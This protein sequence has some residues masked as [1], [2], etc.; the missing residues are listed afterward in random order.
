MDVTSVL[1]VMAVDEGG[2]MDIGAFEAGAIAGA[3]IACIVI[4]KVMDFIFIKKM[5]GKN[6][7]N[8]RMNGKKSSSNGTLPLMGQN[9]YETKR[10]AIALKEQ[11]IVDAKNIETM[12]KEQNTTNQHLE[13]NVD[14][15]R[16]IKEILK[17]DRRGRRRTS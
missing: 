5:N 3:G 10:I 4:W 6:S 9:V 2:H 15:L 13:E 17:E 8:D 1:P 12:C 7:G 14:L 11:G 16:D